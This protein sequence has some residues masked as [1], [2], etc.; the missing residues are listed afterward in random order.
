MEKERSCIV[1][2]I[3]YSES[4]LWIWTGEEALPGP[5]WGLIKSQVMKREK[6]ETEMLNQG[7]DAF[8]LC[9]ELADVLQHDFLISHKQQQKCWL[10]LQKQKKKLKMLSLESDG[11]KN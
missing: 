5:E 11:K 4:V 6:E 3:V 2:K 8:L 7:R 1:N 9:P 10:S